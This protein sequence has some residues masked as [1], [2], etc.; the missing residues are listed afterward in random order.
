MAKFVRYQFPRRLKD[1]VE[2]VIYKS[3]QVDAEDVEDGSCQ[4]LALMAET[5]ELS[6]KRKALQTT[7]RKHDE[8]LKVMMDLKRQK[9]G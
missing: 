2:T 5:E 4:L 9:L 3:L 1:H 6:T 8:A 7:L